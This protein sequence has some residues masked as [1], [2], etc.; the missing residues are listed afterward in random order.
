M[1]TNGILAR[2]AVAALLLA[3]MAAHAQRG[4][5]AGR[6]EGTAQIPGAPLAVVVDLSPSPAGGWLGSIILPGRGT[7]GAPLRDIQLGPDGELRFG[8]EAAFGPAAPPPPDA[9]LRLQA[10]GA[11]AGELHQAGHAAPLR[12]QR[13]G[14]AQ[15]DRPPAATALAPGME[16]TWTGRYELGGVP[17]D[18]TLT[19]ANDPQ[20][21]GRGELVIVGKRTSTLAVDRVV[22]GREFVTLESTEVGYRIE[23]RWSAADR[24][25]DGLVLQGPFEAPLLLRQATGKGTP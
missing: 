11:L 18:V 3:C 8:L 15:V 14:A 19:L 2:P 22:Q 6:W 16:G 13:T 21:L 1:D 7:K 4:D 17:R 5:V 10:D 20:G 24:T 9:V 12:L 23:G 25:I